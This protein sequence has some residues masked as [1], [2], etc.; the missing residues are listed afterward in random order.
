MPASHSSLTVTAIGRHVPQNRLLWRKAGPAVPRARRAD[1]SSL[2]RRSR[3]FPRLRPGGMEKSGKRPVPP[4]NHAQPKQKSGYF[5]SP[6]SRASSDLSSRSP[7]WGQLS[8]PPPLLQGG[9]VTSLCGV[10]TTLQ[11]GCVRTTVVTCFPRNASRVG[12]QRLCRSCCTWG[13][14]AEPEIKG[15]CV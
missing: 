4:R 5:S 12:A 15:L 8:M 9:S 6:I 3:P 14:G 2:C 13:G 1:S 10:P 7:S 11:G